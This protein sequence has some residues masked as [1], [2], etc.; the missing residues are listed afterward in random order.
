MSHLPIHDTKLG[1]I[2]T[3]GHVTGNSATCWE[4]MEHPE[5]SPHVVP[6]EIPH[7]QQHA[8]T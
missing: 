5:H 3:K 7:V 6:I 2:L 8:D 1:A 4:G